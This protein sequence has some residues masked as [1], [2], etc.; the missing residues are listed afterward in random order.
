MFDWCIVVVQEAIATG[1]PEIVQLCLQFRDSQRFT[2]RS[3][4]VPDLLQHL[5]EVHFVNS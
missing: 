3:Q 4:G 2:Q 1:D 5:N